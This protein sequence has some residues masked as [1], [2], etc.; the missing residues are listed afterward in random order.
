[1]NFYHQK[2]VLVAGGTGMIGIPTVQ[3]LVALGARVKV[4]SMDSEAFAARVLPPEVSFERAD[5][6][7]RE[8]CLRAVKGQA[9]VLNLVG[10][11]GSVGIGQTKVASY[12]VPMLRFQTNLME[13]AF[14]E[15]AERFL[16]VSSICSYPRA[17]GA[18]LEDTLWDGMPMQNDRIPGLAKRI[19]EVQAEAYL[20][21]HQWTAPRIVRP[22]NV[23]GPFDDFNPA[24]GQVIPALIARMLAGENPIKIWG[25]GTAIRDF[26]Y[27]DDLADWI[28]IALEKA[29][30][31]LPLNLGAGEAISIRRLADT[32][33]AAMPNPPSIQWD[34]T[35]PTGDPVRLL[36]VERAAR[37]IGFA[38]RVSLEQGIRQTIDWYRDH[39]DLRRSAT[40]N[41]A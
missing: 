32:I 27:A 20:L 40:L 14:L 31:C 13:A 4:V 16:F 33:A 3:R 12:L 22:A 7:D 19:G 25:D 24:T 26:I 17:G 1:M 35:K 28:L 11:K 21:E 9:Y 10:I 36:S 18:K 6:T 30:P 38:P 37:E 15:R 23:Y 2:S 41:A 8:Q 5:L 34:A 39:R 29:P